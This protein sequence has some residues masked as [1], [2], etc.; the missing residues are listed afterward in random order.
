LVLPGVSRS[1]AEIGANQGAFSLVLWLLPNCLG[2]WMGVTRLTDDA[3]SKRIRGMLGTLRVRGLQPMLLQSGEHW[4]GAAV[5]GWIPMFRQLWLGDG[6]I[7]QLT[8]RQLDMVIMHEVS[9]LKRHHFVWRILPVFVAVG[10]AVATWTLWPTDGGQMARNAVAALVA[11]GALLAG[12]GT[13]ARACELDADRKACEL[14]ER[15]CEWAHDDRCGAASELADALST[16]MRDVPGATHATWLHPS[17][18]AR[19]SNLERYA[20]SQA[21]G[22]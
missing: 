22:V 3:L 21:L 13:M 5:V 19:L 12:L 7:H 17:L 20:R 15:S 16:L 6:L 9:H 11:S 8:E 1:Q 4:A 14:A 10:G 2:R 18:H